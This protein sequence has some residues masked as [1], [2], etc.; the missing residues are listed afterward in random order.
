LEDNWA[1]VWFQS[2]VAVH[3]VVFS[4][5]VIPS[6]PAIVWGPG[7][8]VLTIPAT[9]CV[10]QV[11]YVAPTEFTVAAPATFVV[12]RVVDDTEF[13]PV[14]VATNGDTAVP[15]PVTVMFWPA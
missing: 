13:T 8:Y 12:V 11:L 9:I 2:N 4:V 1:V 14:P 7:E 15:Q 6:P 5:L 3:V 10:P